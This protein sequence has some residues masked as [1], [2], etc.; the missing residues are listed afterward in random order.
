[1]TLDV[2]LDDVLDLVRQA[3]MDV[4]IPHYVYNALDGLEYL[5]K[6]VNVMRPVPSSHDGQA[7]MDA[8]EEFFEEMK[9]K[10][11]AR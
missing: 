9:A 8:W 2:A 6:Y 10:A 7:E 4:D 1:M 11:L 5:L 3:E